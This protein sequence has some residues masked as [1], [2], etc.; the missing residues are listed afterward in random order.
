MQVVVVPCSPSAAGLVSE[1]GT[2]TTCIQAPAPNVASTLA[3][4]SGSGEYSFL[5]CFTVDSYLCF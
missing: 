2:T 4:N 5:G 1:Q 3:P